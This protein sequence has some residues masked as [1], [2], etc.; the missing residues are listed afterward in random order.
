MWKCR[1]YYE[2]ACFFTKQIFWW[3]I[4]ERKSR[5]FS[6]SS[7]TPLSVYLASC[8]LRGAFFLMNRLSFSALSYLSLSLFCLSFYFSSFNVLF[9]SLTF[10]LSVVISGRRLFIVFVIYYVWHIVAI[11]NIALQYFWVSST[12][13]AF[14]CLFVCFLNDDCYI[15]QIFNTAVYV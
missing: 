5:P 13:I 1:S 3:N 11:I 4:F 14:D 6:S 10:P 15:C 2:A 12:A 8:W 9:T 7:S